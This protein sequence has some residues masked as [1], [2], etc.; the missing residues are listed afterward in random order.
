MKNACIWPALQYS[1]NCEKKFFNVIT[2]I[3]LDTNVTYQFLVPRNTFSSIWRFYE[4]M[5][6]AEPNYTKLNSTLNYYRISIINL[7]QNTFISL[8]N[9]TSG[10][11]DKTHVFVL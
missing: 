8:G 9:E 7:N 1:N 6:K 11:M 5:A 3:L 4:M 2:N 10:G